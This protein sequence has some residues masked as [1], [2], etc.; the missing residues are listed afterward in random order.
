MSS[1]LEQ[2]TAVSP[3][4]GRYWRAAGP[5]SEYSSEFGLIRYRVKVEI[6]YFL[7]LAAV[8][9]VVRFPEGFSLASTEQP[10]RDIYRGFTLEDAGK[11]KEIERTT[12]HDVKAV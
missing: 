6:E 12:N 1:V 10:L 4:D 8:P 11:V 2:L 5:L 9:E 7:A 3:L